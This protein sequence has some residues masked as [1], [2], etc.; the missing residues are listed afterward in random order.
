MLKFYTTTIAAC[1]FFE[2]TL[3]LDGRI[4]SNKSTHLDSQSTSNWVAVEFNKH[5]WNMFMAMCL[6]AHAPTCK[7]QKLLGKTKLL[8][9]NRHRCG[10]TGLATENANFGAKTWL[11]MKTHM[12]CKEK[13]MQVWPG[14]LENEWHVTRIK[15][16]N[17]NLHRHPSNGNIVKNDITFSCGWWAKKEPNCCKLRF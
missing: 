3:A 7:P 1:M 8:Y 4:S 13:N 17:K 5:V 2:G 15:T 11:V 10:C 16:L 6:H 14:C 12:P 9:D